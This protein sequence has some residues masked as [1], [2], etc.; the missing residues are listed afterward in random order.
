MLKFSRFVASF[1]FI[2]IASPAFAGTVTCAGKVY[3]SAMPL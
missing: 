2:F 3:T 1:A